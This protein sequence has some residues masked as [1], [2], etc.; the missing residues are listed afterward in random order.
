[1]SSRPILPTRQMRRLPAGEIADEGGSFPAEP[2]S[3]VRRARAEEIETLTDQVRSMDHRLRRDFIDGRI[4][5]RHHMFEHRSRVLR[6][7]EA[8]LRA[9]RQESPEGSV[10]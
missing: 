5:K 3:A 4:G 10:H 2:L 9:M 8:R 7:Q 6:Q 1:M